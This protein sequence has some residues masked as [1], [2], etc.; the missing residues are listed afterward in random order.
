MKFYETNSEGFRTKCILKLAQLAEEFNL[1]TL[2]VNPLNAPRVPEKCKYILTVSHHLKF[3]GE[4][5]QRN[6]RSYM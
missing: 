1:N 5:F 3:E 4:D 6:R 2:L